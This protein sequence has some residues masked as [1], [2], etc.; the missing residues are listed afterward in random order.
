M[1]SLRK[2][3]LSASVL[4]LCARLP[5]MARQLS[6]GERRALSYLRDVCFEVT[7]F[8]ITG[9]SASPLSASLA[10]ISRTGSSLLSLHKITVAA[11]GKPR[12]MPASPL[13]LCE[14]YFPERI[15]VIDSTFCPEDLYAERG[16]FD[17]IENVEEGE[18]EDVLDFD[19]I[20]VV[21]QG[22]SAPQG[23][24]A[25]VSSESFGIL[26]GARILEMLEGGDSRGID[27]Q[28]EERA[29][30][31]LPYEAA[32]ERS[33]GSLRRF[34]YDGEQFTV[35]RDGGDIVLVNFY[36]DKLSRKTFDPLYRLVRDERF[37]TGA[38]ARRMTLE[39]ERT[40]SYSGESAVPEKSVEELIA[41]G[42]R[43]ENRFDERGRS[44]SSLESHY[45]ERGAGKGAKDGGDVKETV[46]LDDKKTSRV[47]DDE[48]RVIAE[49]I[50]TWTRRTSSFGRSLSEEHTV[51]NEYDYSAVTDENNLPPS[52]RFFEDGEL[53][54]ERSFSGP[55]SYSERLYFDGGFS[56]EVLYEDGMKRS[57]V[58]Y[59]NG[60]ER[61][62][63]DFEY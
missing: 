53:H 25:S 46:L 56:V 33:D 18:E 59:L 39:S 10:G 13:Y 63:R 58:I 48:G 30:D 19:W 2:I 47:Y 42:K 21:L 44:V 15:G 8:N 34:S 28:E 5:L 37:R 41:A 40:F 20:D 45:E 26:D 38:S 29:G 23:G 62:R 17:G 3:L 55:S 32:Y 1:L 24:S 14:F 7:R 4:F 16:F 36:G 43:V 27:A 6:P 57:E 35:W 50:T 11:D 61:R 31:D 51:R 52:V 22:L 12:I 9:L 49:E 54:L 60:E